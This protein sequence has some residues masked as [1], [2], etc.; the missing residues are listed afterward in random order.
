ME[1]KNQEQ[2]GLFSE[3]TGIGPVTITARA[4][5]PVIEALQAAGA[6]IQP[7]P[8]PEMGYDITLGD[9]MPSGIVA[10]HHN[11][12]PHV[13]LRMEN[14]PEYPGEHA[15]YWL[16]VDWTPCPACG[17][18]VVWYEAGYVPGYRVCTRPPHHHSLA[19]S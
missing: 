8:S 4:T 18:P 13:V 14:E 12:W 3:H 9:T 11:A 2:V 5:I 19:Q 15:D 17:A 6:D 1:L 7:L 10:A 16:Q